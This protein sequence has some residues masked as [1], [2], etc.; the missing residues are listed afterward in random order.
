MKI[1]NSYVEFLLKLLNSDENICLENNYNELIVNL[2]LTLLSLS[3]KVY[4]ENIDDIEQE[5]ISDFLR[6][7]NNLK[8]KIQLKRKPTELSKLAKELI[9]QYYENV[10]ILSIYISNG[11]EL[12]N[13]I[14]SLDAKSIT[15]LIDSV[16]KEKMN[17]EYGKE[18]RNKKR[19]RLLQLL[20]LAKCY[21]KGNNILI[22][23]DGIEENILV[24]DFIEIFSY[25]LNPDNY[26]SIY[27]DKQIQLSHKLI[28]NNIIRILLVN[29]KKND[30]LIKVII[31]LILTYLLQFDILKYIYIDTSEFK[32]DNIL[33]SE[34]YSLAL[35]E[36]NKTKLNCTPRWRNISIPNE[37][38]L[39][40]LQD[41]VKNGMYYFKDNIFVLE[42]VDKNVS[43]FKVSIEV[44]K[45]KSVLR[46][47]LE[48][49]LNSYNVVVK[50]N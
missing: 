7:L 21:I 8:V 34:L 31:P 33:I 45:L 9:I 13:V 49:Y 42:H 26:Y 38:L 48:D 23:K 43:D 6:K 47:M 28:I 1:N 29:D 18:E 25:L 35:N 22:E 17:K 10:N 15:K 40:K 2:Y 3:N 50:N 5:T 12:E 41:M 14:N 37:Y 16:T 27:Q 30:E 4:S 36:N 32:I 39:M 19:L 44:S 46:I 20:P 11:I 24:N